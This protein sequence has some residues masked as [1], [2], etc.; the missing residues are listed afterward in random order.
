MS[1]DYTQAAFTFKVKKAIR[2]LRLYGVS[3]T[4]VKI[5]A[6]NHMKAAAVFDGPRWENPRCR[7]AEAPSRSVAI[8]GCGNYSFSTIAYY[9]ARRDPLFLR[10]AY[11]TMRSR[12][13]SL[14]QAYNGRYAVADWKHI[15]DDPQVKLVY[16]A[17]N[18]A[19]HAE[20]AV[21]CI[22]AR[23]HVHIEKP[24]A[25]T[26]EQLDRLL[27]AMRQHRDAKVFLG[28]NRPRGRLFRELQ[29]VLARQSGCMVKCSQV[30][31]VRD[32][33]KVPMRCDPDAIKKSKPKKKSEK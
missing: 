33:K 27:A 8:I 9:L 11:D 22:E 13:L 12:A 7:D 14:C 32:G 23:K 26:H 15:V 1:T 25:V 19:S 4:L 16:I 2:Y 6:Q 20:Y 30:Y 24:N 21:A 5:R 31:E 10:S 29:T 3:R 28:F 17:S 18:H